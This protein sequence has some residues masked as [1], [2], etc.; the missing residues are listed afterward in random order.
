MVSDRIFTKNIYEVALK[1]SA[2]I[3]SPVYSYK[4]SFLGS[5]GFTSIYG[6]HP[7]YNC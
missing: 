5:F 3:T 7:K 2:A 1:Q 4:L 6:R